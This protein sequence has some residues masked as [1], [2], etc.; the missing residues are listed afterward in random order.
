MNIGIVSPADIGT[1]LSFFDEE[2][3]QQIILNNHFENSAP[4]VNTLV[5]SFLKA[6]HFVRLF[7]LSSSEEFYIK[8]KKIEILG[9]K[10]YDAYPGKYIWGNYTNAMSLRKLLFPNTNGLDI[11]HAHWTYAYA[12]AS[13]A[14]ADT[15]PVFCT[16][17][18]WT[19]LIWKMESLKNKVTWS[20]NY[21]IN[22]Q[23]FSNK[24]IQFIAN[25]PYTASLIKNK[26][27]LEV[28]IIP[29]PV[30]DAF[31]K[32]SDPEYPDN[33]E[34]VCIASSNDKR[35]NVK[36][37]LRAFREIIKKYPNAH[38]NLIGTPFDSS[39][40]D[41]SPWKE[42]GLL[43]NVTLL[44]KVKHDQLIS[45]LDKARLF[46]TPSLEETFGNTLLESLSRKVPVIAGESSGAIPYVLAHGEAGLLCNVG[47]WEEIYK[48]IEFL[49]LNPDKATKLALQGFQMISEKY[50]EANICNQHV[51]LYQS[52]A[53]TF[54]SS[55]S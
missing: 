3:D 39:S 34:I 29:N 40:P 6:G 4:A 46:V 15:L 11:L 9:T 16:V 41:M 37:L 23:V 13:S 54:A 50:S 33:L 12:L 14:F 28:P 32:K 55:N 26:Y 45:F 44:G 35:K 47:K 24:K 19:A 18:D 22:E 43:E 31:L 5:L 20:V 21:V 7:T 25:S 8:S 30:K 38:L 10:A 36:T 1:F 27:K 48:A 2:K 17:R 53:L 51:T 52:K 49:Y 42:E